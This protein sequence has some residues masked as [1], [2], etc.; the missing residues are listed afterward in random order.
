MELGFSPADRSCGSRVL[1]MWKYDMHYLEATNDHFA[2]T[3]YMREVRTNTPAWCWGFYPE[4]YATA[5]PS[6]FILIKR[7]MC[8]PIWMIVKV[9]HINEQR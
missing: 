6:V 7:K 2:S 5:L 4:G 3:L 9:Q 8:L 1:I